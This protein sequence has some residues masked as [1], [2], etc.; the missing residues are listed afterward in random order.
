M[1]DA[2]KFHPEIVRMANAS[3]NDYAKEIESRAGISAVY[4]PEIQAQIDARTSQIEHLPQSALQEVA[5]NHFV[6]LTAFAV[7]IALE[8]GSK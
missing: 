2:S 3:F 6:E 7:L 8:R 5:L 4:S 1:N